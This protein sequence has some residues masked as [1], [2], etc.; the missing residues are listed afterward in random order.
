MRSDQT[1]YRSRN[2]NEFDYIDYGN[3]GVVTS[4]N[5]PSDYPDNQDK[6]YLIKGNYGKFISVT[7]T[8]F[9]FESCCDYVDVYDG[10]STSARK[11]VRVQ[12][13]DSSFTGSIFTSSSNQMLLHFHTDSSAV[14]DGFRVVYNSTSLQ[15]M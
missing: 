14:R 3:G 10:G 2:S 15:I 11:L 8:N 1:C 6:K 12:K 4:P 7:L 9:E 13:Q 5:W